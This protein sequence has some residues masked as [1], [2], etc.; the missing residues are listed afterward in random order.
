[1]DQLTHLLGILL[2]HPERVGLIRGDLG[3]G[4]QGRE[5]EAEHQGH[6]PRSRPGALKSK[7]HV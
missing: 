2:D 4:A 6:A 5:A 3:G 7:D 1:L